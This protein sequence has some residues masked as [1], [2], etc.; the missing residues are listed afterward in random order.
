ME[1]WGWGCYKAL[2]CWE[3]GEAARKKK[4]GGV[5]AHT[6]AMAALLLQKKKA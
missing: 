1:L 2:G 6:H 5:K 3:G 4:E